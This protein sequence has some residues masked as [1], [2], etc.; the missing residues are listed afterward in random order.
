MSNL[1]GQVW[2]YSLLAFLVG[3]GVT[4][5]L[6]VRPARRRLVELEDELARADLPKAK[7]GTDAPPRPPVFNAPPLPKRPEPVQQQL[8]DPV[9]ADPVPT[10]VVEPAPPVQP[11]EVRAEAADADAEPVRPEPVRDETARIDMPTARVDLRKPT[12]TLSEVPPAPTEYL[13]QL[14]RQRE[15][16]QAAS[17][18]GEEHEPL[19]FEAT[20]PPMGISQAA[21][22]QELRAA[23]AT[24]ER[25]ERHRPSAA[26]RSAQPTAPPEVDPMEME[27]A[28]HTPTTLIPRVEWRGGY[29]DSAKPG[30]DAPDD[31]DVDD[32]NAGATPSPAADCEPERAEVNEYAQRELAEPQTPPRQVALSRGSAAGRI[33][34][35]EP[36]PQ[37]PAQPTAVQ[38]TA[39]QPAAQPTA[40]QPVAQPT[41]VQPAAAQPTVVQPHA[42]QPT[43]AQ[44]TAAQPTA[45]Q[46]TA[47]QP[48]AAQPT[49][50]QPTAAV[51]QPRAAQAP[52]AQPTSV[53]PTAAQPQAPSAQPTI[54]QPSPAQPTVAQPHAEPRPQEPRTDAQPTQ[55]AAEPDR[56]AAL[57]AEATRR[58]AE[59]RRL[60]E[61]QQPDRTRSL[62]EPVVEPDT[63]AGSPNGNHPGN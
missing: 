3:A 56:V 36:A 30:G 33:A 5:L 40:V 7:A 37:P 31:V 19:F 23:G 50:A 60:Q 45:A 21:I 39:V 17:A 12:P 42:A 25:A 44:P 34:E 24:D 18:S 6:F 54:A 16:E 57:R 51:A 4:W 28:D 59:L 8:V 53:Q 20:T 32:P 48:T 49:A 52:S 22:Q 14:Q 2:L 61:Q 47:A 1:F 26:P 41:S 58:E 10:Q 13:E 35:P 63:T 55:P 43:A 62:F 9:F 27:L 29:P 15:A 38:P 46:P 11:E